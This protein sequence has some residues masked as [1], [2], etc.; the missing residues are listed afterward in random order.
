MLVV[1]VTSSMPPELEVHFQ[2]ERRGRS[3]HIRNCQQ[4][5]SPAHIDLTIDA[6]R[7]LFG[8]DLPRVLDPLVFAHDHGSWQNDYRSE[9]PPPRPLHHPRR[10]H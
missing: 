5:D 8:T 3:M 9:A 4:P 2:G 7:P 1:S 10:R 6:V